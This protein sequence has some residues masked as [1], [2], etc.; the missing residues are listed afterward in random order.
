[1]QAVLWAAGGWDSASLTP[2]ND[3]TL[4]GR[5]FGTWVFAVRLQ[6]T[7]FTSMRL[8]SVQ[9][10]CHAFLELVC[11]KT[12]HNWNRTR[13]M[14]CL[15]NTEE[16]DKRLQILKQWDDKR[17]P[18]HLDSWSTFHGGAL[19]GP[20]WNVNTESNNLL[21]WVLCTRLLEWHSL[22]VRIRTARH[23]HV[24]QIYRGVLG[25][26][27]KQSNRRVIS[28]YWIIQ[29]FLTW[30]CQKRWQLLQSHHAAFHWG[31]R[32]E[33]FSD[34]STRTTDLSVCVFFSFKIETLDCFSRVQNSKGSHSIVWFKAY[35]ILLCT[36]P[37][38]NVNDFSLL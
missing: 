12:L 30:Q 32:W 19:R 29:R 36:Q 16:K 31:H 1:M 10:V 17:G 22:F 35:S 2:W 24:F 27:V 21:V 20:K 28:L 13:K 11:F 38:Q 9:S 23:P 37:N 6:D 25:A 18:L 4:S 7:R 15:H 14:F 5:D 3:A 8:Q 34:V 26:S 33:Q